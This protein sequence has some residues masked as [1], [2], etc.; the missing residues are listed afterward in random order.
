MDLPEYA[1]ELLVDCDG[2]EQGVAFEIVH[3][4]ED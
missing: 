3:E 2:N 1:L 4:Q